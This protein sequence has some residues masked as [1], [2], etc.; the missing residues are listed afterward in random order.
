ME[1]QPLSHAF[2]L[3]TEEDVYTKILVACHECGN[4]LEVITVQEEPEVAVILSIS[5]CES[6]KQD[7]YQSGFLSGEQN[8]TRGF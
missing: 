3:D 2:I 5:V 6:C 7:V 8:N 4:G 1:D